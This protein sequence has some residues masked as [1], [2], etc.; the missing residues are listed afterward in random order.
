MCSTTTLV[1]WIPPG[2]QHLHPI[3]NIPE[4]TRANHLTY[5]RVGQHFHPINNIP[6]TTRANHM[7]YS[8]IMKS[9][10]IPREVLFPCITIYCPPRMRY[11][12]LA[13]R[14]IGLES[15][16]VEYR[17]Q[18]RF[19]DR[20]LDKRTSFD[21]ITERMMGYHQEISEAADTID[22]KARRLVDA[23][24]MNWLEQR[25]DY[26]TLPS[27]RPLSQTLDWYTIFRQSKDEPDCVGII[28]MAGDETCK[29]LFNT[30]PVTPPDNFRGEG[31]V[32]RLRELQGATDQSKFRWK[33]EHY[34]NIS[35]DED[36]EKLFPD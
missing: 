23:I 13:L 24:D 26:L 7:T 14:F 4:K 20:L 33:A 35:V 28:I 27:H 31:R 9:I 16:T 12:H 8:R 2:A 30:A 3:N 11:V 6:E 25:I 18:I 36:F 22:P 32:Y 10:I 19:D 15:T 5:S 29:T 34:C 17:C 1:A 21:G